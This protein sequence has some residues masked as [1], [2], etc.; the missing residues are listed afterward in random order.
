MQEVQIKLQQ[1]NPV[2]VLDPSKLK[3]IVRAQKLLTDFGEYG[4]TLKDLYLM[5]ASKL[6]DLIIDLEVVKDCT[7]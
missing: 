4:Y 3:D 2:L 1:E 5:G 6:R 7:R